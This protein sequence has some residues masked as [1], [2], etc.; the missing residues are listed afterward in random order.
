MARINVDECALN[1]PRFEVL[2]TLMGVGEGDYARGRMLRIWAQCA[3]RE[4]YVL[5][6]EVI[7]AIFK[8]NDAPD[9]LVRAQ[10]AQKVQNG[11]RIRGT[12]GRT[13]Y[14]KKK[15]ATARQ[16]GKLGGRKRKPTLVPDRLSQ[17]SS[18][19]LAPALTLVT[20]LAPVLPLART[21]PVGSEAAAAAWS[22]FWKEYPNKSREK[23]AK[24]EFDNLPLTPELV[25]AIM[26]GLAR[27]KSSTEW[28][29]EN[30]RFIPQPA[31][32]LRDHR[33]VEH[34]VQKSAPTESESPDEMLR[35]M[36]K[37]AGVESV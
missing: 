35:K 21:L 15:R 29:K 14:L 19:T 3:N 16:N 17:E 7:S 4:T 32:W 20:T 25:E 34:P 5:P 27:W 9:W 23:P 6:A 33:F 1:D 36:R 18:L 26:A 10:L 13:D 11:F 28:Q 24:A 12:K 31:N 2:A 8:T 22:N 37:V 30:G